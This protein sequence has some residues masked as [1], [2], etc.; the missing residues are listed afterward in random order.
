MD[1]R[2]RR[3]FIHGKFNTVNFCAAR[4]AAG[5]RSATFNFPPNGTHSWGYWGAQLDAMK[6]D[7]V[8]TL[9]T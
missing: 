9:G 3:D 4:A 7:I 8:R 1:I 5:G 2:R 6:S